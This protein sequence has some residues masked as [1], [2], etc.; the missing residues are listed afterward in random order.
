MENKEALITGITGQDGSYLAELLLEKGYSVTG[1]YR[2]C[3][4]PNFDRI[5]KIKNKIN[6]IEGDITD[7]SFLINLFNEYSFDEVY[8]LCA[9]SHVGTSFK[10]PIYTTNTNYI[11]VLNLLECI[12][13]T[14]WT[15]P[16]LY[17][18]STSEMFGSNCTSTMDYEDMTLT[19]HIDFKK[20]LSL[21]VGWCRPYQN[22]NTP[23]APNSPYS[24]A[25]LAAHNAVRLY[26]ESYGIYA[27]AGIL[28]NHESPRRG[29]EFVTKKIANYVKKCKML[30]D[31]GWPWMNEKLKL[32]NLEAGRDWG[33]AKDYVEAMWLML[34]QD[35]ADDFVIATA[36]T[37]T[38]KDFLNEAF[39]LIKEDWNKFVEIDEQFKRPCEVPYLCGSYAKAKEKFGWSPKTTFKELVKLMVE[40]DG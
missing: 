5:K 15:K 20:Y 30:K 36:E 6:L 21:P 23:F 22:E 24:I 27:C 26:R 14:K 2:R 28:F 1:I 34:Q 25:K 16:R 3:S 11:G 7:S 12:K 29:D 4:T 33:Y 19:N 31:T 9:Q 13:N 35:K 32:G 39:G 8:N 38:V 40:S 18:A 17:Q 10:N 37:H